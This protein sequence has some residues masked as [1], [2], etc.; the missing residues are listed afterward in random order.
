MGSKEIDTKLGSQIIYKFQKTDG[1]MFSVYGF[2]NLNRFMEMVSEGS[3]VRLTYRGK[4]NVKTKFGMKDVHQ[5]TV[6]VDED[7]TH[8]HTEEEA[9]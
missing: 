4:E 2:T 5:V 1:G 3:L 8:E 7:Y 6:E 9:F